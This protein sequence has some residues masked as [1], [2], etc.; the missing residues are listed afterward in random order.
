MAEGCPAKLCEYRPSR[1]K[2]SAVASPFGTPVRTYDPSPPGGSCVGRVGVMFFAVV[3]P[4]ASDPPHPAPATPAVT[5]AAARITP[6]S[7]GLARNPVT[8]SG[9][10][11]GLQ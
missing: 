1:V 6:R 4:P 9:R 11:H 10:R 5:T 3:D 8:V 7:F 2:S